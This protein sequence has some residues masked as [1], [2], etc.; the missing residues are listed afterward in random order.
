MIDFRYHVVSLIAVF[1]A[2]AVGIVLGAGPLRDTIGETLTGQV[3]DLRADRD[4]LR[5]DLGAAEAEI[6]E[7]TAYLQESAGVLLAGALTDRSVAVVTLPQTS[8]EHVESIREFLSEAGAQVVGEVAVTEAWTDPDTR[9]FRQTFAGQL[10]GYLDTEPADDAGTELVLGTALGTALTESEA[11]ELSDDAQTLLDLLT[12]AEAPLITVTSE[13]SG[14][15]DATVLVGPPPAEQPAEGDQQEESDAEQ[16]RRAAYVDLA[17]GLAGTDSVTVGAAA[18]ERDLVTAIREDEAAADTTTT[19]DNIG[20]ITASISTPLAL[21]VSI[22]GSS[23][24]YGFQEGA[25]EPVPPRVELPEDT[26]DVGPDPP[27]ISPEDQTAGSSEEQ[28]DQ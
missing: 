21:A 26:I 19:V 6:N 25:Q 16:Q 12:S 13:L 3:E 28:T 27:Q 4:E 15:A 20:E 23:G 5:A 14:P 11:D 24:A 2:L 7:R 8:E 22:S 17:Q 10:A 9:S 1:M 18:S